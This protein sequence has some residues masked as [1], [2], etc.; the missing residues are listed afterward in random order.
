MAVSQLKLVDGFSGARQTTIIGG[1][2]I[3]DVIAK[4]RKL[5]SIVVMDSEVMSIAIMDS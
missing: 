5:M 1:T 4:N 2:K 3:N